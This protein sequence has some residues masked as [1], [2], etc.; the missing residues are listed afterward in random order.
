[1]SHGPWPESP[2]LAPPIEDPALA[3]PASPL[4]PD[5]DDEPAVPLN[6]N[7][8]P[9]ASATLAALPPHPKARKRPSRLTERMRLRVHLACHENLPAYLRLRPARLA[10]VAPP[11]GGTVVEN[12]AARVNVVVS[13]HLAGGIDGISL[14]SQVRQRW[15]HV[16]RILFTAD[17]AP[18]TVVDAVDRA[19]V[20]KV[21]LKNMHAVQIGTRSREWRSMPFDR[22]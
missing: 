20:H 17:A 11:P 7:D 22:S 12:P 21:L 1:M 4:E 19:G 6:P 18:D 13:D 2:A 9:P 8:P 5:T 10:H 15:P 16:Q 3:S 14:L